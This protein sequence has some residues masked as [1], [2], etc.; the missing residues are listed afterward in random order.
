MGDAC[1]RKVLIKIL[2]ATS[3]TITKATLSKVEGANKYNKSN[4]S[5]TTI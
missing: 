2:L 5:T 3:D 1:A 4:K